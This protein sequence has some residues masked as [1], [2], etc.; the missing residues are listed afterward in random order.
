MEL[1]GYGCRNSVKDEKDKN[2]LI[3]LWKEY[4][5]EYLGETNFLGADKIVISYNRW[6][7]DVE[8]RKMLSEKMGLHFSDKGLNSFWGV[9]FEGCLDN[10]NDQKLKVLERWKYYR[11]NDY[12]NSIFEDKELMRLTNEIFGKIRQ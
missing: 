7:T 2:I 8:Y 1:G 11:E 12:Y 3:G 4:A 5:E 6:V 9:P 10:K